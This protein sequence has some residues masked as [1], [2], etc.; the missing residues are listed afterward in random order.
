MT[1]TLNVPGSLLAWLG[2]FGDVVRCGDES[3][4][5]E[6][7][8]DVADQT[9]GS[10]RRRRK[11]QFERSTNAGSIQP[12]WRLRQLQAQLSSFEEGLGSSFL[13]IIWFRI[14]E[15]FDARQTESYRRTAGFDGGLQMIERPQVGARGLSD[16]DQI[17]G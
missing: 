13:R 4:I 11:T 2:H 10:L 17:T 7:L 9:H 15:M 8:R 5:G 16:A 12:A 3:D 6:C 1:W 14:S